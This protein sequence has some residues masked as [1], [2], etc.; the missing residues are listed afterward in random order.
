MAQVID[1]V[2]EMTVDTETAEYKSEYQGKTYYFCG[3]G[4]KRAFD[5]HPTEFAGM[6]GQDAGSGS[7]GHGAHH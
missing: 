6:A 2:C 5:K 1:P 3:A 4:C 7:E